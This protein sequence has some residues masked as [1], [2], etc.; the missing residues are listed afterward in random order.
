MIAIQGYDL[1]GLLCEGFDYIFYRGVRIEDRKPV[2]IKTIKDEY[3]SMASLTRVKHEFE[4]GSGLDMD[5]VVTFYD[6]IPFEKNLALILEDFGGT[7][8]GELL[9]EKKLPLVRSLQVA[10][11]LADVLSEIHK[12][13]IV[14]KDIATGNIF[15]NLETEQVK[16]IDM[17]MATQAFREP[18]GLTNRY[19][20]E[21]TLNF[22]SPELTGRMNRT[23]DYRT[24]LYSLGATLYAML[25]GSPPFH[26]DDPMEII[27]CHIA[28]IPQAPHK[29]KKIPVAVS[30]IV[31]K[32]LAK[33]PED[34]YQSAIGLKADL[35]YCIRMLETDGR[36]RKFPLGREDL[37]DQFQIPEQLFG[38]RKEIAT[39]NAA[40]ERISLGARAMVMI[41]G[42]PGM[43]KT[44]LVREIQRATL[45]Q[46]G[47]FCSGEYNEYKKSLPFSGLIQAFQGLIQNLFLE[48]EETISL[49]R[50]RILT[51][52][53]TSLNV[54]SELVP[55]LDLIV[56]EQPPVDQL[57]PIEA[58]NRFNNVFTQFVKVFARKE[59]PL[60]LFIDG[61]HWI[62]AAS[63]KLIKHLMTAI[64]IEY[65]LL[66]GTYREN[67]ISK[68]HP[69]TQTLTEIHEAGYTIDTISLP[70]LSISDVTDLITRTLHCK[71]NMA[72]QLAA[73]VHKKTNGT[74]FFLNQFLHSLHRQ[75]YLTF[76]MKRRQW[77]WDLKRIETAE[78]T[79]NVVQLMSQNIEDLTPETKAILQL[80]ACIGDPFDLETLAAVREKSL[81][82]TADELREAMEKGLV[83][84][85]SQTYIDVGVLSQKAES[86]I[87]RSRLAV[88]YRFFSDRLQEMLYSRM[89]ETSRSEVHLEIGRFIL[90]NTSP[91]EMDE[92]RFDI[93]NQ[94]NRG[95]KAML[96]IDEVM[97]LAQLN[98]EAGRKAKSATAYENA[99]QYLTFGTSLLQEDCWKTSRDLSLALYKERS[100]C[101][102][103]CGNFDTAETLFDQIHAQSASDLEKSEI[104]IVRMVLYANQGK[105]A[106]AVEVG[107]NALNLFGSNFPDS[108]E[109]W[110]T[111]VPEEMKTAGALMQ[112][113]N[114][115]DLVH[116]PEMDDPSNRMCMCLLGNLISPAYN[117]NPNL[118]VLTVLRMVTLSLRFGLSPETAYTYGVYGIILNTV[119]GDFENSSK[120]G[121]L[122]LSLH[123]KDRN[124]RYRSKIFHMVGGWITQWCEPIKRSFPLLEESYK[125][126]F[127]SGD[128]IYAGFSAY[129][130][131]SHTFVSGAH[132][133]QVKELTDRY[134][135]FSRQIKDDSMTGLIIFV[136]RMLLNLQGQTEGR[137][138]FNGDGFD[139]AAY[140]KELQ[141][142]EYNVGVNCFYFLKLQSLYLYGFYEKA[143][144]VAIAEEEIVHT[145]PGFILLPDYYFY[146]A[147]T[148]AALYSSANEKDKAHYDETLSKHVQMLKTWAEN[149]PENFQH[150]YLLVSG[151][152]ARIKGDV[153]RAMELYD[154]AID[155]AAE[156]EFIQIEALA[157]ERAASFYLSLGRHRNARS[158]LRDA[159][160]GYLR[161]GANGKVKDLEE[162]YP[163]FLAVSIRPDALVEETAKD[164]SPAGDAY[165]GNLDLGTVIKASQAMSSERELNNLLKRILTLG[166]ENAGAE[167]GFLI[168]EQDGQLMIEA[169]A[170]IGPDQ[171]T[172]I[173]SVS[174][175]Q[176]NNLSS[177]IVH[178]VARTKENVVLN[179]AAH[180]GIFT[181]NEY[182]QRTRPKSILC[183]PIVHK[184]DVTGV[185][186]LE[187]NLASGAFTADR[188][189]I[190]QLLTSQA[191]IAIENV[192]F[193]NRLGESEKNYRSLFENAIEGIF[194]I[195]LTG[196]I[197]SSN[198]SM[199][200]IMGYDS[201]NEMI[202]GISD[203]MKDCFNDPED[204]EAMNRMLL[205]KGHM[206][207]FETKLRDKDG[208]EFWAAISARAV[209]DIEGNVISYEGS[210]VNIS[211][212]M[213]R[214][215]AE[216]EREAAEMANKTKSEFLASMSHEIR[217]P[218]NAILG[219]ADL[220]WESSLDSQQ[221]EYVRISRNAGQGLLDLINDIL[222]L[223]KVEA[224][225]LSLE[226]ADL[227]LLDVVEKVCEVMAV[228]AHEKKLELACRIAPETP[229]YLIGDSTRLRQILVNL[230]GNAV[231]FTKKGEIVLEID[232]DGR[233]DALEKD[234]EK[235]DSE[236]GHAELLFSVRDT[237]I[238]I[239]EE[240]QGKIFERFTQADT[241]TTRQYGG[242]GL[243]LAICSRLVSMMDG[244]IWVESEPGK[245]S[246]FFF[247]AQFEIQQDPKV[248]ARPVEVDFE[249][250]KALVVDDNTVNRLILR[251]TL[252][253]WGLEVE[254]AESGEEC[255]ETLL[256]ADQKGGPFQL[257]L[258]DGR[259][260]GMDGFE[261]AEQIKT[262]F[263]HLNQT[264]MLLTSD[265]TERHFRRSKELGIAANLVKPV[266]RK[267]LRD[268]IEVALGGAAPGEVILVE[269][270]KKEAKP[271]HI[272][273]VEDNQDNQLLFAAF[274]KDTP[275]QVVI[276]ENGK[277]GVEKYATG[278][279]DL[280]FM[281][282][283]MPVMDGYE[284]TRVI[285]KQE[286]EMNKKPVP[287][288]A[289]TA[290]ALKGKEQE[291]FAAGCT[292]HMTKP[293][294]KAEL[295]E[296][297]RVY[298]AAESGSP[299]IS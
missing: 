172:I 125:S 261:T 237:G 289:L 66:I 49:W 58:Q 1:T 123:E 149:C 130:L 114:I 17:S 74:P 91:E 178:Y 185:L 6:L 151:E 231:K 24:D 254:S 22:I 81:Q 26:S 112:E 170:D 269:E 61:L 294:K 169:Q 117:V 201:A 163:E 180:E 5:G 126:G 104:Y 264:M 175:E 241:S 258:L 99:L 13:E 70:P 145:M 55:Q 242:T 251:E 118:F 10:I 278:S 132:F 27:Y 299:R 127:E 283:E 192:R 277:A 197:L 259:M 111:A 204:V 250:I 150:R 176:S 161:W 140:L 154:Q 144:Q 119:M 173:E 155:S 62:D 53:G 168:L 190:L 47:F 120:F 179:D 8:L 243:G 292:N 76:D 64:D 203:I 33:S 271:L 255:L 11:E 82:A 210:V 233:G 79:D 86:S 105:Y 295:L 96:A 21:G 199:A 279:Y 110:E 43:G 34:R 191:A 19:T 256:I 158:Y 232:F 39:L 205:E 122:A 281:D 136:Q 139:E 153:I 208:K 83:L 14:H 36:I 234:R 189:E 186:Y 164:Y 12:K 187:N 129:Q 193:Y 48:N 265:D 116:A 297:V 37:T 46:K 280:V 226:H 225:Q 296:T 282:M 162:K 115:E 290:H 44:A 85:L 32:L 69:L 108:A 20:V 59:H 252:S 224:G 262:R 75:H 42:T 157:R 221:R 200:Q 249:G 159:R 68:N 212:R 18:S 15:V 177:A 71:K 77:S 51:N 218:M 202:A 240:L 56:G 142:I 219:M 3:P 217:T 135:A 152:I 147:L 141:E 67:E 298:S 183:I 285:R 227:D 80:A 207:D 284:A 109:G 124:L 93:V 276:A 4:I 38:R 228:K 214:E 40:Y 257:I 25:V 52:L 95:S 274:M 270:E 223:S 171:K 216:R 35:E 30:D 72:K 260:P 113:A 195:S 101:E 266:K 121:K 167:R 160:Y 267:D 286:S 236:T 90:K 94:L 65:F 253:G 103:L 209:H 7:S 57:D 54:I 97:A 2:L 246:N 60:C 275:H 134:L 128:F 245:G 247:T 229:R 273:L 73:L 198:P 213:E 29:L 63:L 239:P 206:T 235:E 288:I 184:G 23:V 9:A 106:E 263:G 268:A 102:Y 165:A 31:M 28:R 244:R 143:Y 188:V 220:L 41:S 211:E 181:R 182:V 133:S 174:V 98:L 222:D 88:N 45:P 194:R 50:E 89:P 146:Y 238:G 166:M 100:E 16:I 92:E 84:P 196:R 248:K 293:F 272:L 131:I 107:I 148:L 230:V 87:G 287:I 156:N 138:T 215:K 291:S 78:I 137:D